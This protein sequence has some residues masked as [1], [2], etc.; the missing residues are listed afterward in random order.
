[1]RVLL[2]E[3]DALLGKALRTGLEQM[4]HAVDWVQD[5]IAAEEAALANPY[6]AVLLDLGLPRR[7]GLDV[8]RNLRRAGQTEPILVIT[9]RDEIEQ[10]VA[11]LDG[12]ADDFLIKPVDLLELGARL[13]A[14]ARRSTGRAL[15]TIRIGDLAIDPSARTVLL[16]G[17]PVALTAREMALLLSLAE[18]PGRVRSRAQLE[19]SLYSWGSSVDSNAIEVHIH[20]LRRKLGRTLIQTVHGQG[21]RIAIGSASDA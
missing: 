12:G 2:V 14:A 1:M 10:R 11:G 7:D 18:N 5:G 4:G 19:E 16:A 13:R 21:Y 6:D 9:A 8:L 15:P 17:E 3:D 20:H